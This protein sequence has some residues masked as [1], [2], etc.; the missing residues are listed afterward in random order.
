L[1]TVQDFANSGVAKRGGGIWR[2]RVLVAGHGVASKHF[3]V[4]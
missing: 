3:T 2:H 1:N 4:K